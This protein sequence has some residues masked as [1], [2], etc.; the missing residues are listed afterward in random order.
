MELAADRLI[1]A[2][3]T[4]TTAQLTLRRFFSPLFCRKS[5][6]QQSIGVIYLREIH[7]YVSAQ[8]IAADKPFLDC[9]LGTQIQ[10][11]SSERSH[12]F[13]VPGETP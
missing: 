2:S 5:A 12:G 1:S 11:A 4:R 10:K 13:F 7:I 8:P 3:V 6:C 9:S